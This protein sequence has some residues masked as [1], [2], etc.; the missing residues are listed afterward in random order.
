[1]FLRLCVVGLAMTVQGVLAEDR[2][3]EF[4]T[5]LNSYQEKLPKDCKITSP[6][7]KLVY[8]CS[9][10]QASNANPRF[11]GIVEAGAANSRHSG[12]V[13]FCYNTL[14]EVKRNGG[15]LTV[16]AM[17]D[18][19]ASPEL[20]TYV[21]DR[22]K[23]KPPEGEV[24]LPLSGIEGQCFGYTKTV[25]KHCE[26][27]ITGRTNHVPMGLR[28]SFYDGVRQ[29]LTVDRQD[30]KEAES[31]GSH[32]PSRTEVKR[33]EANKSAIAYARAQLLAM[34]KQNMS[35]NNP[36]APKI[37]PLPGRGPYP[38]ESIARYKM[39]DEMAIAME[40]SLNP[41]PKANPEEEKALAEYRRRITFPSGATLPGAT[42]PAGTAGAVRE[43]GRGR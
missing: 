8:A 22:A 28:L 13:N 23:L 33:S 31:N 11:Y 29:S 10:I 17:R 39:C 6:A 15:Q 2:Q 41:S 5:Q 20:K 43:S 12:G 14:V 16:S 26:G 9:K 24:V 1:M 40:N 37:L 18:S 30:L 36:N 27:M 38:D 19:G 34:A 4:E 21:T 25:D 7:M 42:S 35:G 32:A 3:S